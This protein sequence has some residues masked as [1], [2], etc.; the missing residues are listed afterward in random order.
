[1]RDGVLM[2]SAPIMEQTGLPLVRRGKV[3]ETYDLGDRLLMVATDRVS[4]FDVVLPTGIPDKGLVLNQMSA[5]WFEITRPITPNHFIVVVDSV[6]IPGVSIEL[7]A[8]II[9]RSMVVRKADPISAEAIV[10]GYITGSGWVDYQK[11]G[12]VCGIRLPNGFRESEELPQPIFT[13]TTKADEGHDESLTFEELCQRIGNRAAYTLQRRSLAVY[14][15]GRSHAQTRG[16]IVAD[17][18]FEFGWIGDHIVLIDEALTPD[19]SRFWPI[20]Q[21]EV[22]RSQPSLDKQFVRDYGNKIGWDKTPP[23]PELPPEVVEQTA[24]KYRQA[25]GQLTGRELIRP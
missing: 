20:E 21:Y 19:S 16:I 17:T 10:R 13:P 2:D 7:P 22:G 4:I 5:Y 15:Y 14:R 25:F 18:K 8:E 23:G 3:R 24:E 6:R 11:D 1:M 12:S 9:G